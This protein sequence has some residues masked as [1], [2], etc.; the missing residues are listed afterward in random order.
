MNR[1]KKQICT[2]K[3]HGAMCGVIILISKE[4]MLQ[5]N[6]F[7]LFYFHHKQVTVYM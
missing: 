1:P 3:V 7:S 2:P 4:R 5:E 6:L